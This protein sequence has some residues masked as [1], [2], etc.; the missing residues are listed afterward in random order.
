MF[1]NYKEVS[2]NAR[3]VLKGW[4][5]VCP[6][7]N[8]LA[9]RGKVP[10]CGAKGSGAAFIKAREYV[11]SVQIPFNAV[12]EHFEADTSAE[13]FGRR[14][15]YPL[16]AAPIM[17]MHF[18]YGAVLTDYDYCKA[19]TAGCIDAGVFAFTGDGPGEGFFE[20][21]L[22]ELRQTGGVFVPTIK[23]WAQDKCMS[24]IEAIKKS[25]A[26]AF[27]MD[28]DSADLINLK[29]QGYPVFT[30]PARELKEIA[31]A[32]GIPF[33]VKGILTP[34]SAE[35]C[36][37]AG[38]YGIVVS[39]HGGRIME[40]NPAP[41]SVLPEIKKAV[42]GSLKIFVD[43][44]IRSGADVFKCLA[45]GADA[46][47]IGRPFVTAV[48]GGR[49]EGVKLLCEKLGGELA[50]TM[51]MTDCRTLADVTADKVLLP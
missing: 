27:A 45:L 12:H 31:E 46:V 33:I 30:K 22:E 18:N 23:P 37:E 8:G 24:R 26:M 36:A 34:G 42:G 6:D 47:L 9:C 41:L 25:G 16:F 17:G 21:V 1:S 14:F 29:L 19:V 48:H 3:E 20:P 10:G 11:R 32:A 49:A 4:C 43:G 7:C 35:S 50:E 15:A 28:V 2:D 51:L 39:N 44:G 38:A 5:G 40:D 13:L